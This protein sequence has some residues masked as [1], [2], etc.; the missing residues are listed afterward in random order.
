MSMKQASFFA[1]LFFIGVVS[2]TKFNITVVCKPC[3]ISCSY[4]NCYHLTSQSFIS[5]TSYDEEVCGSS[6]CNTS[7]NYNL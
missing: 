3:T 6:S 5:L 1:L 4:A 2:A 7:T